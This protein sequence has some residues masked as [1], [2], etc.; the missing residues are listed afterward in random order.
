MKLYTRQ[1]VLKMKY[2]WIAT[3]LLVGGFFYSQA[4]A[5]GQSAQD[6][7]PSEKNYQ[8]KNA[9]QIENNYSL[10]LLKSGV[11]GQEK[12]KLSQNQPVSTNIKAMQLLMSPS[13]T[14]K[15]DTKQS[16]LKAQLTDILT[17]TPMENMIEPISEQ[18][19]TVAAFLVGIAL[20]ESQFGKHSPKLNGQDCYNYWGYRGI[21]QKM[22][23][24]GHTCFDSPE[25][26]VETVAKRL[27]T[28]VEQGR[29]TPQK[30]IIWKCGLSC[31]SHSPQS[32]SKWISDVSIYFDK[33]N[34]LDLN[35]VSY[36]S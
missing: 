19:Q 20:K 5:I 31:A 13:V 18:N 6:L 17:G 7:K 14:L 11:V 25:D 4:T 23:T 10:A 35:N 30:M 36:S 32:V 9:K 16:I 33:I 26:A 8:A 3:L 12:Y 29:T 1:G 27:N 34:Q 2:A 15:E 24:G 28:L 22:G 21:R